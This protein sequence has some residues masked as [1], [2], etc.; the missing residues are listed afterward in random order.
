MSLKIKHLKKDVQ[1]K[2]FKKVL[3]NVISLK[4]GFKKNIFFFP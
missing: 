2:N 3:I 4:T 1:N